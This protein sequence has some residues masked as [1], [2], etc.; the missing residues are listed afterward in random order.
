[1]IA[2]RRFWKSA[3]R[4][5]CTIDETKESVVPALPRYSIQLTPSERT[6]LQAAA[7]GMSNPQIAAALVLSVNTVK[8]HLQHVFLKL[9]VH[10]RCAA[11]VTATGV[12]PRPC[13]Q[14]QPPPVSS[15]L[16]PRQQEVLR[17]AGAG[18]TN[19]QIATQLHISTGTVK[20]HIRNAT[21]L[22][23]S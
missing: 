2:R 4:R 10:D 1:V 6:V 23:W 22:T 7:D 19:R 3:R 9:G 16:T 20:T 15:T 14:V 13:R 11:V 18:M 8:A 17:L 21:A 12:A 5:A